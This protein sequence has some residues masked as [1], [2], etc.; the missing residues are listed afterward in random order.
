LGAAIS[1]V[2]LTAFAANSAGAHGPFAADF[3]PTYTVLPLDA[4]AEAAVE[5]RRQHARERITVIAGQSQTSA[6]LGY[7]G[8]GPVCVRLCDG[9]FFPLS[10]SSGDPESQSAAC[11]SQCPDAPTQVFYRNGSDRI[12]DAISNTGQRYSALPVAL[13][14]QKTS[15]ATCAC[16]RNP[17]AYKPLNDST[18]R[19]GD[20]IVTPAGIFVFRGVE[21]GAHMPSDFTALSNADMPRLRRSDMLAMER[22]SVAKDHPTL[23]DW[24]ASQASPALAERHVER[25]ASRASGGGDRIRLLVW[26][27]GAEE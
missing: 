16:H 23:R 4:R 19:S 15:D 27:G 24:L 3:Q 12:E 2:G 7:A 8:S 10:I 9:A 11:D 1:A 18:L 22:V 13:R 25:V 20:A 17:V 5:P 6:A 21:G 14:F 26:R